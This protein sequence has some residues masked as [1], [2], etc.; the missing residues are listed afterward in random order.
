M[1]IPVGQQGFIIVLS[2]Q[3]CGGL[4]LMHRTH[5]DWHKKNDKK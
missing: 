3:K 1:P 2:C 4:V 5:D